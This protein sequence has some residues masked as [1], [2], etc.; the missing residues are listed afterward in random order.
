MKLTADE[1]KRVGLFASLL[2]VWFFL[3]YSLDTSLKVSSMLIMLSKT[4][5]QMLVPLFILP[6]LLLRLFTRLGTHVLPNPSTV[7]SLLD[8]RWV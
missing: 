3:V 8:S 5:P 7:S 6:C 2:A 4:S 1:W